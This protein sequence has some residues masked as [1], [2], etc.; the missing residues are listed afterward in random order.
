MS[1]DEFRSLFRAP[2]LA[3]LGSL[4]SVLIHGGGTWHLTVGPVV[5]A[6]LGLFVLLAVAIRHSRFDRWCSS[7]AMPLR[8]AVYAV[9]LFAII[10]FSSVEVYPFIYFQF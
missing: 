8:W 1:S 9:M 6:A 4:Y 2:S 10:V 3:S 5:W 7:L